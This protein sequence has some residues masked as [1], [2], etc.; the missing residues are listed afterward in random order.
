[1]LTGIRRKPAARAPALVFI[2]FFILFAL[3]LLPGCARTP[4][5]P[6]L[7]APIYPPPPAEPRFIYE[8]TLIY[9]DDVEEY[10]AAMRFKQFALG[11]S[12]KLKGLVKPFD[13]VVWRGRVYVSDSVQR[14]VFLFDIPGKRFVEIGTREPGML[15]KPLGMDIDPVTGDLYVC[16]ITARRI[17]VYDS[18]GRFLRAIGDKTQLRRPADAALSSDGRRLYVV[19]TGGVDT[20]EHHVVVYDTRTGERLQII[21]RRGTAPGEFNLPVQLTRGK[22]DRIYVVDG[23]NFRVQAFDAQGKYLFSFGS[24]GRMPGQF[25]RPKGIAADPAGRLYVVD[26]AF[27]NFQIFDPEGRLLMHIGERGHAGLPGKYMLPAGIDVDEDGRIYVV[28]QFFR[29]VDVFRPIGLRADEGH[30]AYVPLDR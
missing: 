8:R 1:M 22:D 16:D 5:R 10:T 27:G 28:D 25:A 7:E 18:E 3:A 12:R 19:D 15:A 23:G 24:I 6:Q 20:Q 11:A 30:A 21:G 2:L 9:N 29:K 14:T 4:E 26:T 17:M 13:V